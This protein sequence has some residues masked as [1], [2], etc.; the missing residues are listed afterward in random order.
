MDAQHRQL[1]ALMARLHD[2]AEQG[3]PKRDVLDTL[4]ALGTLTVRHFREE[5]AVMMSID[6]PR[7]D[8]HCTIHAA[9]LQRFGEHADELRSPAGRFTA[10]FS[11]FLDGWL[12]VHIRGADMQYAVSPERPADEPETSP[13]EP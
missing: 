11:A 6:F 3:A 2:H 9:L 7:F 1:I 12:S 4:D 8:H 5:E 13:A 10:A